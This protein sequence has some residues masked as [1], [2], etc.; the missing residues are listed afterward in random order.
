MSIRKWIV[1]LSFLAVVVGLN[2]AGCPT[3]SGATTGD[4]TAGQAKFAD[5]C[6]RCHDAASVAGAAS[7]VTTNMGTV[8]AAMNGVVL[9]DAEVADVKAFL[10]TQ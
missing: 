1:P 8:N 3:Q 5:T 7:L 2:L 9:T 10:A 4:A 6:A